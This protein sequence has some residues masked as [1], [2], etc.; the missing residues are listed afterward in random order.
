MVIKHQMRV[1]E[2]VHRPKTHERS[3]SKADPVQAADPLAVRGSV[4]G[5]WMLSVVMTFEIQLSIRFDRDLPNEYRPKLAAGSNFRGQSK[6]KP[7]KPRRII[8]R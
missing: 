1:R 4:S 3:E 6:L 2:T 5:T 7:L 8:A